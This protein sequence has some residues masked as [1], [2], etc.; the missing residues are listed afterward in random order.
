MW[1]ITEH[2]IKIHYVIRV[3]LVYSKIC[4]FC[5][6]ERTPASALCSFKHYNK[7]TYKLRWFVSLREE[8]ISPAS[9]AQGWWFK[10][11]NLLLLS[12]A[13][14]TSTVRE[15]C[16]LLE[17]KATQQIEQQIKNW[18]DNWILGNNYAFGVHA[19]KIQIKSPDVLHWYVDGWAWD[20]H[21]C[22]PVN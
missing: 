16:W 8:W 4:N 2:E 14:D 3:Q 5:A 17:G 7:P 1:E 21:G 12:L 9:L 10:S 22:I 6:E 13:T 20:I 18:S 15:C 11:G 19:T